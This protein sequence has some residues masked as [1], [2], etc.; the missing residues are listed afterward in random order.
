MLTFEQ[1]LQVKVKQALRGLLLSTGFS[2]DVY[3]LSCCANVPSTE[4]T[5]VGDIV[6]FGR[7]APLEYRQRYAVVSGFFE[8]Q[9]TVHVLDEL[10]RFVIGGSRLGYI[11]ITIASR[12]LRLDSRVV[13]ANMTGTTTRY[14]NG[15]GGTIVVHQ[16]LAP[17]PY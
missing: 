12:V 11:D 14:F 17:M 3:C 5:Q 8:D 1:Q 10:G 7:G 16:Q 2:G 6:L 4:L 15:L 13:V 9:R